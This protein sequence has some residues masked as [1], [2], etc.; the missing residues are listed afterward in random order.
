MTHFQVSDARKPSSAHVCR[1]N[2]MYLMP[3]VT[4]LMSILRH[5]S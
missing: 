2:M 1:V 3:Y 4:I 5:Y